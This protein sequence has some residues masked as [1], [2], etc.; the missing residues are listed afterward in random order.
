VLVLLFV[1]AL[2]ILTAIQFLRVFEI[3]AVM[4]AFVAISAGV[5]RVPPD[6]L[7]ANSVQ[8]RARLVRVTI[9]RR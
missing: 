9:D 8:V 3:A 2:A 5:S 6:G 7:A 1:L 4:A